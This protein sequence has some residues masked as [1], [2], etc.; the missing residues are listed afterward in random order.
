MLTPIQNTV[1][2]EVEWG[3]YPIYFPVLSYN[4]GGKAHS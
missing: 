4:L 1:F 2:F 3:V